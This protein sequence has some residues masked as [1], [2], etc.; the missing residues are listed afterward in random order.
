[1]DFQDSVSNIIDELNS[2]AGAI[3]NTSVW[4]MMVADARKSDSLGTKHINLIESEI[5]KHINELNNDEKL[6]CIIQVN[7][8]LLTQ[9]SL[10]MQL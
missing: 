3:D 6:N 1:M 8:D 5:K 4:S 7:L 9:L 10:M 2:V